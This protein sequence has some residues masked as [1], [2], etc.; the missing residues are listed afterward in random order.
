[1]YYRF[2]DSIPLVGCQSFILEERPAHMAEMKREKFIELAEKRV[3]KA[4]L[5]MKLV[6]NLSNK[7]NYEYTPGDVKKIT[8]ALEEA[9]ADVKR[10]FRTPSGNNASTFKLE[11]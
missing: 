6:G 10:R 5:N 11:D 1:M 3:N 9:V 4:I 7:N 2:A 8:Q